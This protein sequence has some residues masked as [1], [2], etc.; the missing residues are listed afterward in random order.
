LPAPLTP[1]LFQG[2]PLNVHARRRAGLDDAFLARLAAE[3]D[4]GARRR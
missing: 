1:A 3:P 2:R 4:P